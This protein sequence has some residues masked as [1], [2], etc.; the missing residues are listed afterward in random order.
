M[1]TGWYP[2]DRCCSP[3]W[4]QMPVCQTLLGATPPAQRPHIA[5]RLTILSLPVWL[6]AI[7]AH[8]M[9]WCCMQKLCINSGD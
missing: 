4:A 7:D 8:P 2:A 5:I 9:L 1:H 6:A 3:L